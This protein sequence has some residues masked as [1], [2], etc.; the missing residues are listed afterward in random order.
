MEGNFEQNR[1]EFMLID[2]EFNACDGVCSGGDNFFNERPTQRSEFFAI[3]EE[4]NASDDD[5]SD[6]EKEFIEGDQD[7]GAKKKGHSKA[8]RGKG[9]KR[10][11]KRGRGY[12]R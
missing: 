1:S 9:K 6:E 10:G 12:K 3:D 4:F 2:D 11:G 5:T 8:K 7:G